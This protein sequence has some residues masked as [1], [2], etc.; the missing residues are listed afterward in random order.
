MSKELDGKLQRSKELY[1]K[2]IDTEF[3]LLSQWFAE[4][5][6]A[7]GNFELGAELEVFLLDDAF[8]LSNTSLEVIAATESRNLTPEFCQSS[9]EMQSDPYQVNDAVFNQLHDDLTRRLSKIENVVES[10]HKRL[11]LIGTLPHVSLKQDPNEFVTH[12]VRY[13]ALLESS[14]YTSCQH[15]R[16]GEVNGFTFPA[17]L[18]PAGLASAF[19]IQL[20]VPF[21]QSSLYYNAAVLSMI[22]MIALA[23]NSPYLNRQQGWFESRIP[24]Y[25]YISNRYYLNKCWPCQSLLDIFTYQYYRFEPALDFLNEEKDDPLWHLQLHFGT[26]YPFVR[27]VIG[28]EADG[29][30][31][32]RLEFRVLS[33]A[34]S[35]KDNISHTAVW[36]AM[37]NWIIQNNHMIHY[38]IETISYDFNNVVQHGLD[39]PVHWYPHKTTIRDVLD[40]MLP[41]LP[42]MLTDF[43]ISE[44]EAKKWLD[45]TLNRSEACLTASDWQLNFLQQQQC[46]YREMLK[47][48]W[49]NQQTHDTFNQW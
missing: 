18:S 47:Q 29:T 21:S 32:L 49:E 45:I 13:K 16:E 33:T 27:P 23:A 17:K 35:I 31:H 2:K 39:A 40:E 11:A 20:K 15:A 5:R 6:F 10:Q 9:L 26:I 3:Q 46:S 22:P 8:N 42:S 38:D 28:Y 48:Y 36:L 12:S 37:M 24:Y 41:C 43:N 14:S 4:G 30:P 1:N 7:E 44:A 25:K 19:Q 34:P